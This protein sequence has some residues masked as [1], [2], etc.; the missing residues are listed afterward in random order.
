[1]KGWLSVNRGMGVKSCLKSLPRCIN[2]TPSTEANELVTSSD[3]IEDLVTSPCFFDAHE[4]GELLNLYT[5]PD[6]DCLL[7]ESPAK[8]ASVK[9][10]RR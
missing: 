8:S 3:S 6:V 5:H 2:H 9:L 7:L 4:T 1:M 10:V